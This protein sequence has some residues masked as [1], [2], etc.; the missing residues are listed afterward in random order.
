VVALETTLLAHGL[1]QGRGLPLAA[2]IDAII[3]DRGAT[4]AV[5]GVLDGR[6]VV[7]MSASEL[8]DFLARP[9]IAKANSANLD[10]LV[11]ARATA[12][13]TV[14]ATVALAADAGV[15]VMAT[16]GLGGVHPNLHQRLDVSADLATLAR[17]AVAVVSSGVKGLLDVAS[18][19]E[20]LEAMGVPVLGYQTDELP[21][22]Y[23][24]S[25]GLPVDARFDDAGELADFLGWRLARGGGALVV[26]PVPHEHAIEPAQWHDWLQRA[27]AAA[28][29]A[30]GRDRTP[31]LLA[32]LHEA[33]GGATLEAN[34]ALVRANAALAAD[35]AAALAGPAT[36][37][38]AS[39]ASQRP[40]KAQPH[41]P[42]P[43]EDTR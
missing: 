6:P 23:L 35:V 17:R 26:R 11:H 1:P 41:G 38:G 4:P 21:A 27:E 36:P 40:G 14:S 16:G 9:R 8:A 2:E 22:F 13:T 5:V 33:S 18:T 25:S 39:R 3:R 29:D 37:R 42:T 30:A 15:R 12:A 7:G 31:A 34:C 20:L 43:T 10:A 24:R 32:A 28:H 19:R